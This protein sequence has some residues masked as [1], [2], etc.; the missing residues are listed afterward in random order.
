MKDPEQK[1]SQWFKRKEICCK[2]GCGKDNISQVLLNML[3][4]IRSCN[5]KPVILNSVCRCLDHNKKEGGKSSSAHLTGDAADIRCLTSRERY[6]LLEII[7][8]M[9][10]IRRIGIAKSFIHI[11]IDKTKTRNV[12]WMY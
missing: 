12:I 1:V 4:R 11:D 7:V 10:E 6:E 2:C 8:P 5:G 3:D 9:R